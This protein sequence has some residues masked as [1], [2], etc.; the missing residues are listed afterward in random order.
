[1]KQLGRNSEMI[2]QDALAQTE[3]ER[4]RRAFVASA[5]LARQEVARDGQVMEAADVHKWLLARAG[6]GEAA[7]PRATTLLK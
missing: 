5:L 1:M 7:R 4:C 2:R 6:G 3:R